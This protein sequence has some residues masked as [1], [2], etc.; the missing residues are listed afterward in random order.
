[1]AK[2]GER[3]ALKNRRRKER[4]L[5]REDAKRGQRDKNATGL[6]IPGMKEDIAITGYVT[7]FVDLLGVSQRL[8]ELDLTFAS[9]NDR[10]TLIKAASKAFMPIELFR[11]HF[12]S[13]YN[14]FRRVRRPADYS[15]L[16]SGAK[17]AISKMES[18]A[19]RIQVASDCVVISMPYD[20]SNVLAFWRGILGMTAAVC[21]A[22]LMML[23][24]GIL[25]RGG[26]ALGFS[27]ELYDGEVV[28]AS[29][30]R[31]VALDKH[32]G[33]PV[34]T[35]DATLLTAIRQA[36]SQ[37]DGPP[38]EQ[39]AREIAKVVLQR[40]ANS[41]GHVFLDYTNDELVSTLRDAIGAAEW[42]G[43]RE[44]VQQ[45]IESGA[46]SADKGVATKH[47]WTLKHLR[48]FLT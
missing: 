39:L 5:Q 20:R 24:E 8:I 12:R 35:I 44:Q 15:S 42:D 41:G 16:P 6:S 28:G 11:K 29:V 32:E 10:A 31:A 30:A 34:V 40:L 9:S 25:C 38:E 13:F 2:R 19:P 4:Q 37:Q 45:S 14:R 7:C 17:M 26:I 3:R 36:A 48:R 46:K 22:Q 1:M 33:P 43:F 18:V 27:C 21:G 47:E 23:H